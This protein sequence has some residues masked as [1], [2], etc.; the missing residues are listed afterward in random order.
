MCLS[1]ILEPDSK[2]SS[3]LL[4]LKKLTRSSWL[5]YM[6]RILKGSLLKFMREAANLSLVPVCTQ[7]RNEWY[8]AMLKLGSKRSLQIGPHSFQACNPPK[9][10]GA[11]SHSLRDRNINESLQ[12]MR[13]VKPPQRTFS[14]LRAGFSI[15][16]PLVW[17][18]LGKK[19]KK[20]SWCNLVEMFL[21][22][23]HKRTCLQQQKKLLFSYRRVQRQ[24]VRM[25][26][27][28]GVGV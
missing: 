5:F 1:C 10:R 12:K 8:I 19:K 3:L 2:F 7:F 26:P 22:E 25:E 15:F 16:P 21:L 4:L 18:W 27:E 14:G 11:S 13:S 9:P 6:P 24:A 28:T 20:I 17:L 23:C